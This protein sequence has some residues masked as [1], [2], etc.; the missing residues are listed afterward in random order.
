MAVALL[1]PSAA[2]KTKSKPVVLTQGQI[3]PALL[4]LADMPTGYAAIAIDPS[5]TTPSATAGVCN[6]P[7]EAARAQTQSAAASGYSEFGQS[8][9]TGPV[10]VESIYSFPTKAKAS[11]F[12]GATRA[13]AQCQPYNVA[14]SSGSETRSVAQVSVKK[15]GNDTASYRVTIQGSQPDTIAATLDYVIVRDGNNV[16]N[17][18][19]GG[20]TGANASELQQLV[21]K[22]LSKLGVAIQAAKKPSA[23][24]TTSKKK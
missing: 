12:L 24:T 11:A 10:V 7:N 4:A 18:A 1:A 3:T 17:V 19:Q 22:A 2:A 9:T 21:A 6:G 8:P 5:S 13:Q 16:V 15:V 23:T 14:N 20:L